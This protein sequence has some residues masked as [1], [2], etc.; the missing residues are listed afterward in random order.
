MSQREGKPNV[1]GPKK[2]KN[3]QEKHQNAQK[4]AQRL[5]SIPTT[6]EEPK[7]EE[8]RKFV[9]WLGEARPKWGPIYSFEDKIGERISM[10]FV[11]GRNIEGRV[12]SFDRSTNLVLEDTVELL[13]NGKTRN[14]GKVFTC[15]RVESIS[16][17]GTPVAE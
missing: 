2:N 17:A 3:Q 7:K 13:D 12:V 14:L 6:T 5:S 16:P 10:E 11:S 1:R 15:G 9:P 8:Q 4:Q